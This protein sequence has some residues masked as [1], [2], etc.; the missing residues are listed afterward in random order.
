MVGLEALQ[1]VFS[2]NL[3]LAEIDLTTIVCTIITAVIAGWAVFESR[4][5]G[6]ALLSLEEAKV[7][8]SAALQR[9]EEAKVEQ[10]K[11]LHRLEINKTALGHAEILYKRQI[12]ALDA[13]APMVADLIYMIMIYQAYTPVNWKEQHETIVKNVLEK[14]GNYLNESA[15]HYHVLGLE[16]M[17]AIERYV[18]ELLDGVNLVL[19]P[20]QGNSPLSTLEAQ[21]LMDKVWKLRNE[22]LA[23]AWTLLK[24]GE[25]HLNR[26]EM[27]KRLT[28]IE[29]PS[30]PNLH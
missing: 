14:Y 5:N 23:D 12:D 30:P 13:L 22:M 29:P 20:L 27:M 7:V 16:I 17:E 21:C 11:S 18:A 4:R 15:K 9:L 26:S 28:S 10:G 2:L 6:K 19:R 24:V 25:L 3:S 1:A 8:Q